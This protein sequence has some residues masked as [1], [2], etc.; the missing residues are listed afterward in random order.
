[1]ANPDMI[2][3]PELPI[4]P[5]EEC[6]VLVEY[7]IRRLSWSVISDA[8]MGAFNA[9]RGF[10]FTIRGFVRN[11][12]EAFDGYLGEDRMRYSNP[13][14][15]VIFLSAIAAFAMHHLLA[16]E[17]VQIGRGEVRTAEQDA[18]AA[19]TRRNYNLLLLSSL[20]FMAVFTRWFYWG[21][22]YNLLEHLAL[23]AFQVSVITLAYFVALPAIVLWPVSTFV[24]LVLALVY[25]VW[26]YRQ[27][28]GPSWLRAT[29]ATA[30]VTVAYMTAMTLIGS[31]W[32]AWVHHG[33]SP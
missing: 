26:L 13:L 15:L 14:K 5:P 4:S 2:P 22:A 10:W 3:D 31:A 11:P 23:N 21:R 1:M 19:F 33:S 8:L 29:V 9:E 28:F 27:V 6:T 7:R 24:Y 20:P 17:V 16:S 32:F 18:A 30:V 12:R 25:Q